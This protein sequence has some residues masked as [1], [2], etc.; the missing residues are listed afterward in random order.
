[1]DLSGISEQLQRSDVRRVVDVLAASKSSY[2]ER[3]EKLVKRI[4]ENSIEANDNLR[5]LEHL[6]ELCEQLAHADPVEIC[7]LLPQLLSKIRMI[8]ELSGFYGANEKALKEFPDRHTQPERLTGLLRKISNEI[9]HRCCAK[10]KLEE[11]FDGDVEGSMIALDQSIQCGVLWKRHYRRTAAAIVAQH[12]TERPELH[13]KF[14]EASIFAQ[15]DA[16]VQRCRDL[17]EVCEG[18]IQFCRTSTAVAQN[19]DD[20][21]A[22]AKT[23]RSG[24]LPKFGG[25]RGSP[26]SSVFQLETGSIENSLYVLVFGQFGV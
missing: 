8:W 22:L 2:L 23:K 6:V 12:G 3:F 20:D 10:I 19:D 1:M 11:I 16:F 21:A 18:Q 26:E 4:E 15:I 13:W 9:I 14:D 17:I 5:F 24:P 25:T 7:D